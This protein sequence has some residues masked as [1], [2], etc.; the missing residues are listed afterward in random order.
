[1]RGRAPRRCRE[2]AG[3]GAGDGAAAQV[4]HA[5]RPQAPDSAR[6]QDRRLVVPRAHG[7]RRV[8]IVVVFIIVVLVV[9]VV[10]TAIAAPDATP[11]RAV[12]AFAVVDLRFFDAVVRE[13]FL[14]PVAVLVAALDLSR[15]RGAG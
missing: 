9:L 8:T 4:E 15:L 7:A 2:G 12:L 11:P 3:Q 5:Q 14:V 1:M 6:A 10:A 13:V